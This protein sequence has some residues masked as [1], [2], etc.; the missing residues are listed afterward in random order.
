M[1]T[2]EQVT[3]CICTFKRPCFLQRLLKEVGVQKTRDLF[4]FAIVVVDNDAQQSARKVVDDFANSSPIKTTY[5]VE[6]TSNI[7]LARNKAVGSASGDYLA[8]IDDDE[9]PTNDW[10]LTLLQA[11]K[12][13]EA[14]GVLGPVHP[15]FEVA[16]PEWLTKGGFYN[17]PT[18]KT[19]FVMNWEEARTGNVL[20]RK[21]I[22]DGESPVF[23]PEFGTGG[24]DQDFFRRMMEKG[25]TFIWCDEAPA[26]ETIP[27]HRWECGFLLKRALLR[28]KTSLRH[29][30][31][32]LQNIAKSIVAVPLYAIALPLLLILGRHLFMK[33]FVRL[34]DHLGR[35][36]A[37]INLNPI[38]QRCN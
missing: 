26:F 7:A 32:R 15:H 20:I 29:P 33:Y 36:L 22:L 24:E 10:L 1:N 37:L 2:K 18:H 16:P 28:G 3:V 38:Q 27:P 9:I 30:K 5:Y 13:Y 12:Q 31:N 4:G 11:C 35:L 21:R 17:R 25:H 6:P 23:R 34:F 19:G 14:D 8:F